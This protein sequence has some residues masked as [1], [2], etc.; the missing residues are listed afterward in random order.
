MKTIAELRQEKEL[1]QAQLAQKVDV[2]V[3][4][5]RT[6]EQGGGR[7]GVSREVQNKIAQVLGEWPSDFFP[8][9]FTMDEL[10][11]SPNPIIQEPIRLFIKELQKRAEEKKDPDA[12]R[13]IQVWR[14]NKV[15]IA[16]QILLNM[17]KVLGVKLPKV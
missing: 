15:F 5:I 17:A 16:F 2:S 6:I 3:S 14:E 8:T 13:F 4:W 9:A 10:F 12:I 7:R 11:D 1:T